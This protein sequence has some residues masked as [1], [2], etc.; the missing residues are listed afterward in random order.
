[1]IL[2]FIMKYKLVLT[3]RYKSALESNSSVGGIAG[4]IK[5]T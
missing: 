3:V 2:K 1:M 5:E 4:T